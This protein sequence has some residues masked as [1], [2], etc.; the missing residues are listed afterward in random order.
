MFN[1]HPKNLNVQNGGSYKYM[2]NTKRSVAVL[3]SMDMSG[4]QVRQ[5]MFRNQDLKTYLRPK[6]FMQVSEKKMYLYGQKK[7]TFKLAEVKF[8]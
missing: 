7:S 2:N 6:L 3:V 4:Q 5:T 1:D 8:E